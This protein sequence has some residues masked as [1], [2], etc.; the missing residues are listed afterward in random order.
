[1]AVGDDDVVHKVNA[2]QLTCFLYLK[3]ERVILSA[4]CDAA[5]GMVM[6]DGH[7]GGVAEHCFAD[8]DTHV[9]RHFA[10]AAVGNA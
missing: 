2:H 7:D 9:D 1:M 6:T 8:D 4:G 3:G 5:T 10:D